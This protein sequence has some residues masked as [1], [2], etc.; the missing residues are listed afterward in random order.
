MAAIVTATSW[1]SGLRL[2]NYPCIERP[3]ISANGWGEK[4]PGFTAGD[5]HIPDHS[6]TEKRP[7]VLRQPS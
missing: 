3:S 1:T 2:P 5:D 6:G 4:Y 7:S